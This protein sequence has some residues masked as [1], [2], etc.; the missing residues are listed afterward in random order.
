MIEKIMGF[1]DEMSTSTGY[2]DF[3]YNREKAEKYV[4]LLI[5]KNQFVYV[6]NECLMLG[7]VGSMF[8]G[9]DIF[10][11]DELIYVKKEFRGLG[12]SKA[13]LESFVEWAESKG[14]KRVIVGQTTG[15]IGG[16]FSRLASSCGF[17]KLGEVYAR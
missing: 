4:E 6:T 7:T 13:A 17:F 11:S 9:N 16:E 14:A 8:F 5:S 3:D 1:L 10:A 2:S 15:V 12:H